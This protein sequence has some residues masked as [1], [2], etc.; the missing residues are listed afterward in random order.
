MVHAPLFWNRYR[1][2]TAL[3]STATH[4][5]ALMNINYRDRER[6]PIEHGWGFKKDQGNGVSIFFFRDFYILPSPISFWRCDVRFFCFS[7]TTYFTVTNNSLVIPTRSTSLLIDR[8]SSGVF[9]CLS[10]IELLELELIIKDKVCLYCAAN[11]HNTFRS[12]SWSFY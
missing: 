7:S 12:V 11:T 1:L 3:V 9:R 2:H 4:G 6:N 8:R 10:L 5:R